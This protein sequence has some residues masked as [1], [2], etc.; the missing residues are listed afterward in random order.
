VD[1]SQVI[2]VAFLVFAIMLGIAAERGVPYEMLASLMLACLSS[3]GFYRAAERGDAAA[4]WFVLV[5]F[6]IVIPVV[7][8]HWRRTRDNTS[9]PGT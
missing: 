7:I 1:E 2:V 5:A 9:D 8:R 3:V 4:P 6:A